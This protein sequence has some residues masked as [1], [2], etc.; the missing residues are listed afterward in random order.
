MSANSHLVDTASKLIITSGERDIIDGHITSLK[1]KLNGYFDTG[2]ISTYFDFGSYTRKT[3]MPRK[4]DGRSDVDFMIIFSNAAYKP[5][6]YLSWLRGFV[7]KKYS[8]SEKYQDHP[9]V[10]LELS[11]IKIELVPAIKSAYDDYQIPAPSSDYS[12]WLATHPFSFGDKV[13][14]KN[15]NEKSLIRPLIRLMKY[16]NAQN[17]YVYSSFALENLIVDHSYLSCD[18][19]WDYVYSFTNGLYVYNMVQSKADKVTQLKSVCAQ[20]RTLGLGYYQ[21]FTWIPANPSASEAEIK[22]AF[23]VY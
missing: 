5:A 18:T 2:A 6:T 17:G 1:T 16:W 15:T 9:T 10:V 22:K 7:D 8:T 20:A 4:A 14:N 11:K 3:L 19:L 12:D 23:P 21:G 13:K